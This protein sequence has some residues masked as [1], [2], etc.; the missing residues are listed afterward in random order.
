[1]LLYDYGNVDE[2][3]AQLKRAL[4]G[5]QALETREWAEHYRREAEENLKSISTKIGIDTQSSAP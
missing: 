2:L 1:M 4:S 3:T 5:E